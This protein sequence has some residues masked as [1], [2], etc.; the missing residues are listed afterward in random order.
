MKGVLL[1]EPRPRRAS[2]SAGVVFGRQVLIV[3]QFSA[4]HN[5]SPFTLETE[6]REQK[7][8]P[9]LGGTGGRKVLDVWRSLMPPKRRYHYAISFVP[10]VQK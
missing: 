3:Q 4:M 5:N 2:A 9:G 7:I 6:E 1:A 8:P 10:S